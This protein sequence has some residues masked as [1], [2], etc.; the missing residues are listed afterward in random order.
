MYPVLMG[1][2]FGPR[3]EERFKLGHFWIWTKQWYC[4][5]LP[6]LKDVFMFCWPSFT[7]NILGLQVQYNA[8]TENMTSKVTSPL[9]FNNNSKTHGGQTKNKSS[10]YLFNNNIMYNNENVTFWSCVYFLTLPVQNPTFV[11]VYNLFKGPSSFPVS[12]W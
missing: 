3:W 1:L 12:Y 7:C 10:I 6:I 4:W 8:T 5:W 11:V 2:I 9:C